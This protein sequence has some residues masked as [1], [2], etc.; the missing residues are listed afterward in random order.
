MGAG[1]AVF[2]GVVGRPA[3]VAGNGW[4]AVGQALAAG[5]HRGLC[6]LRLLPGDPGAENVRRAAIERA[7]ER[8]LFSSSFFLFFFPGPGGFLGKCRFLATSRKKD[9]GFWEWFHRLIDE[10]EAT[11]N[12]RSGCWELFV[13]VGPQREEPVCPSE[14]AGQSIRP[15]R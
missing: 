15:S 7:V 5:L 13:W 2:R 14:L 12:D 3:N 6:G 1:V 11:W 8:T 4:R 9:T 10:K